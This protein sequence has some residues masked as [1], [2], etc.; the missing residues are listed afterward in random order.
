MPDDAIYASARRHLAP[1]GFECSR[2]TDDA[3]LLH[4]MSRRQVDAILVDV[5]LDTSMEDRML[6]WM[7]GSLAP[8]VPLIQQTPDP[9]A[10]RVARALLAG[11]D[12]VV[13]RSADPLELAARIRASVRRR[14]WRH[15]TTC[16][17]VGGF[18]FD[19]ATG[20]AFDRDRRI[21]LTAREFALAWLLFSN[22]GTC[23]SRRSISVTVWGL[24][25]DISNRSMEQHIHRLRRKL[26]IDES[27][28]V[29]LR[30]V[31]GKGYVV[32]V[33]PDAAREAAPGLSPAKDL[34]RLEAVARPD[35]A[36]STIP[37]FAGPAAAFVA[38]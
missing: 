22:A 36:R 29:S 11:V 10:D 19:R 3:A 8:S 13:S 26:A 5:G 23:L 28:A 16:L 12:D 6:L 32:T 30:A 20:E 38:S 25:E 37:W 1:R 35:G 31:Y 27:G 24:D 14:Q 2:H 17:E 18:R 34:W 9:G 21:E 33:R 4:L 15:C 7:Q